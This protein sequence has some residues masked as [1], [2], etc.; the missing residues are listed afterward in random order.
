VVGGGG[1]A[2]VVVVVVVVALV[3]VGASVVVDRSVVVERSIVLVRSEAVS[4]PP[5]SAEPPATAAVTSSTMTAVTT[6]AYQGA[7]LYQGGLDGGSTSEVRLLRWRRWRWVPARRRSGIGYG[8]PFCLSAGC[9][10]YYVSV[11]PARPPP[12]T[13]SRRAACSPDGLRHILAGTCLTP[14]TRASE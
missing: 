8:P 7:A 1:G 9:G 11:A 5:S 2:V 3:L 6:Q 13:Q 4:S 12:G 14:R 10:F